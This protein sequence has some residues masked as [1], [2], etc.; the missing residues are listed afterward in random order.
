MI[1]SV[2]L[3]GFGG[4]VGVLAGITGS[5]GIQEALQFQTT[6]SMASILLA[7]SFSLFVGVFFGVYPAMKASRLNPIDALH[8][9]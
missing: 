4:I 1:E 9:E 5:Y 6:T 2:V 8:Y 7:F 3:S